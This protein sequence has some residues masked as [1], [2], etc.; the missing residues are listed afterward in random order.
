M[1]HKF[2]ISSVAFYISLLAFIAFA[3]YILCINQEVFYTAHDRSE[4]VFGAPYFNT[5]MSKPFGLMQ[6]VGAWL[7]QFFCQPVVG[8]S[9]LVA[10]WVAIYFVGVKAFRLQGSASAL[11]LLPVLDL[12]LH[13]Q[14][15]LVLAVSW[16]PGYV[17]AFVGGTSHST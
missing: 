7:T 4:F 1:N 6:Y 8:S 3:V 5:L 2:K 11:M 16:L 17:V 12:Y 14:G 9:I 13:H 10:I 15:L